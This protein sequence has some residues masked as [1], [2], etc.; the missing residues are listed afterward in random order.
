MGLYSKTVADYFNI[1]PALF[2]K[3]GIVNPPL[4]Q[5]APLFIDPCLLKNSKF[6]EFNTNAVATYQSFFESIV[7]DVKNAQILKDNDKAKVYDKIAKRFV[8]KEQKGLCLGYSRF[9]NRGRGIGKEKALQIFNAAERLI[10][11][12]SENPN[13]F[14]LL[15][16]LE[17]NIGADLISDMTAHIIKHS[18]YSFTQSIAKELKIPTKM[19]RLGN[20]SYML[21]IH[22]IEKVP[23]LLPPYDIIS[24]LPELSDIDRFFDGFCSWDCSNDAIKIRVNSYI[25]NI[26]KEADEL[27]LNTSDIK[28]ELRDYVYTTPEAVATISTYISN[29]SGTPYSKEKDE[30]G[31]KIPT[32]IRSYVKQEDITI[33]EKDSEKAIDLLMQYFA[34]KISNDT[35]IK[36]NL[37]YDLNNTPKNEAAWQSI[38]NVYADMFLE[39]NNLDLTAEAK[40]GRGPVDFK[41][42]RGSKE[43]YLVEMKLSTNKKYKQGLTKQLKAY[44][45][46]T[47]NVKKAYYIYIDFG[48][49]DNK[50]NELIKIKNESKA[51]IDI[52]FIDGRVLPSAS[53]L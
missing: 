41:I 9:S 23:L 1:D 7:R 39:T 33:A 31:I 32:L 2:E 47:N 27:K 30:L 28:R 20:V 4:K 18:L 8:C 52:V 44:N 35:E 26:F 37:L 45:D 43:R 12:G 14:S 15:C 53:K 50:C 49:N 6:N 36:R 34:K 22:P 16:V 48:D 19:G 5:D 40:T 25:S 17:D 13:L 51:N 11:L 10:T 3:N 46:A 38:F 29:I 24:T 21:P 42:S